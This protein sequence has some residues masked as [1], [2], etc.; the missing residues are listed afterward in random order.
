MPNTHAPVPGSD[1]KPLPGAVATSRANANSTIEVSLKLRRKKTL[2]TLTK[3]PDTAMT[4]AQFRDT[5]GASQ[6]DIDK[7]VQVLGTFGLTQVRSRQDPKPR[8]TEPHAR[9]WSPPWNPLFR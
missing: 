2:A 8:A 9:N 6:A 4:R 1:R 5:Y 3:R 7:V